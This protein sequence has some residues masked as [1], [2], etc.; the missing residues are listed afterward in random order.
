[1]YEEGQGTSNHD[2]LVPGL[3]TFWDQCFLNLNIQVKC[4]E[5][6]QNEDSDAVDMEWAWDFTFLGRSPDDAGPAA[7]LWTA[8]L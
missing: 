4:L 3:V 1:M 2:S 7:T 5:S 8:K 6:C